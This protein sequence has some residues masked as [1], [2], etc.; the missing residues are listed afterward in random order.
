MF[1]NLLSKRKGKQK[2]PAKTD[3][4]ILAKNYVLRSAL[5]YD[6][7]RLFIAPVLTGIVLKLFSYWLSKKVNTNQLIFMC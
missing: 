1:T 7:I 4:F 3:I 2:K 6:F 5:T